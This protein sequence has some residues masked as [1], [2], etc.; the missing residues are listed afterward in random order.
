MACTGRLGAAAL[1][2]KGMPPV[3]PKGNAA[4]AAG[5]ALARLPLVWTALVAASKSRNDGNARGAGIGGAVQLSD[6]DFVQ[7]NSCSDPM[8]GLLGAALAGPSQ[9]EWC[10]K[11][12]KKTLQRRV[13]KRKQLYF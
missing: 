8:A 1:S 13:G 11:S 2:L 5:V 12:G 3:Q 10:K 6:H 4:L 7:R 9:S